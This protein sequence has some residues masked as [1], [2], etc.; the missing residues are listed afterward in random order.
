MP[1][2][3][4]S[5]RL[6]FEV[7]RRD[8]FRCVYCGAT[9]ETAQLVVDHIEPYSR[10]GAD[11]ATNFAT[12]C[13]G[14]NAGKTDRVILPVEPQT[15]YPP[16][17]L[18]ASILNHIESY[19]HLDTVAYVRCVLEVMRQY[20]EPEP[21][22][23]MDRQLA[24][25]SGGEIWADWESWCILEGGR[26]HRLEIMA[27]FEIDPSAEGG[28]GYPMPPAEPMPSWMMDYYLARLP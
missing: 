16:D 10:G 13:H 25:M 15:Y 2:K 21:S 6:R 7:L 9:A 3:N 17:S 28:W 12:A 23:Y 5:Q 24:A 22:V 27:E 20:P 19:F 11:D 14:C 4:I 18:E 26:R 1:R 8:N